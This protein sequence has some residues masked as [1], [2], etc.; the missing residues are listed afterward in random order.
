MLGVREGE[1]QSSVALPELAS[2]KQANCTFFFFSLFFFSFFF[3]INEPVKERQRQETAGGK[4]K[5]NHMNVPKFLWTRGDDDD[6]AP[7]TA[8]GTQGEG[9]GGT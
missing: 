3:F 7:K 8:L 1:P 4:K 5:T 2:L 9:T 6:A